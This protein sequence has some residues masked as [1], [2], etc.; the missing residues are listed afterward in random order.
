MRAEHL[1]DQEWM[2][3]PGGE[4]EAPRPKTLCPGCRA[5]LREGIKPSGRTLCF[6]CYRV[7]LE[8]NRQ[9][10]AAGDLDTAS[11]ARFQ[12]ALP[13][14]PVDRPRLERLR[15]ERVVAASENRAAQPAAARRRAAQIEA[16]HALAR[17]VAGLKARRLAP[18]A[19]AGA[20][21]D[22]AHAAELQLPESWIAIVVGQN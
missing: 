1:P 13:F 21:A 22:V 12:S 7:D 6:A 5:K 2:P 16:R 8:R 9:L 3:L 20:A 18:A 17:I 11:D 15:V 4:L 19:G 14:E 10:T